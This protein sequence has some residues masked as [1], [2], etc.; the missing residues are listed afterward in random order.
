MENTELL[1]EKPHINWSDYMEK[2]ETDAIELLFD[3]VQEN[4]TI[5]R[6]VSTTYSGYVDQEPS[7]DDT[8]DSMVDADITNYEEIDRDDYEYEDEKFYCNHCSNDWEYSSGAMEH[9]IEV[10][11]RDNDLE[12]MLGERMTDKGFLDLLG[13][14]VWNTPDG[15]SLEEYMRR[16]TM[17]RH[18]R[19]FLQYM[20]QR[21]TIPSDIW[22]HYESVRGE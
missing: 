16:Y 21:G 6:Y 22:D 3:W 15:V 8:F 1:T 10:V 5:L 4:I 20:N 11:S 7:S 13:E 9:A 12:S 2:D 14:Y 17:E 19:E 18:L